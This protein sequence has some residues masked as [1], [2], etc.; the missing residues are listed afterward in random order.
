MIYSLT[1]ELIWYRLGFI[2]TSA[3]IDKEP[4]SLDSKANSSPSF[5]STIL[6]VCTIDITAV[7]L[8][9]MIKA[10]DC[11]LIQSSYRVKREYIAQYC[12]HELV[13]NAG[14]R[15][16]NNSSDIERGI[17]SSRRSTATESGHSSESNFSGVF[18]DLVRRR[19]GDSNSNSMSG[20]IIVYR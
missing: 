1:R 3:A 19:G 4:I 20:I 7:I 15:N 18:L 2:V 8:L 17:T 12:Q 16:A 6:L 10:V 13:R 5:T 11:L 9:C 14:N